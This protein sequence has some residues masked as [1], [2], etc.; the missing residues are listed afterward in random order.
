MR[1]KQT[2]KLFALGL[3]FVVGLVSA[4]FA[5][6]SGTVSAACDPATQSCCGGVETS[7]ITCDQTGEGEDVTNTGVWGILLLVLNILTAGVGVVALGG[8]V[9]GAV[10]YIS[11]GGSPEQIKKAI[12]IF[13][14]VVIG[15]IAFAGMYALLNFLVPGGL[16]NAPGTQ[17]PQGDRNKP[18]DQRPADDSGS[19]GNGGS[20]NPV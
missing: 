7:L 17:T 4:S 15:V 3:L 11:A 10:L 8:I 13:T 5:V 6:T 14:N 1:I 19:P 9:Y 12:G 16:F 20:N 18:T 2:V